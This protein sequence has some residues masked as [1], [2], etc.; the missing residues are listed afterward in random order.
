MSFWQKIPSNRILFED[1][2]KHIYNCEYKGHEA[3][4]ESLGGVLKLSIKKVVVLV[5]RLEKQ[6][7]LRISGKGLQLTP[8]GKAWALQ[9]IRAHRLWESYLSDEVGLPLE[10]LHKE[11]ERKEHEL[12]PAELNDLEARLGFPKHDPHGD[13]I[14]SSKNEIKEEKGDS[15]LDWPIGTLARI[16]HI[17]DEPVSIFTQILS[18]GLTLN[19]CLKVLE[20]GPRGLRIWTLLNEFWLAPIVAANIF[21]DTAPAWF[22]ESEVELA[23][24]L[25]PGEKGKILS[26]QTQGLNRR[27]M[28]D[29]GLVPGT[30]IKSVMISAL[31][32]PIAFEVRGSVTALRIEQANQVFIKRIKK[33]DDHHVH[34][35]EEK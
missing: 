10:K 7:S 15:I 30:I 9:V 32:D 11:A 16:T 1:A 17:E 5:E 12:S 26:I 23:S 25:K 34:V 3:S 20:S 19:S 4:L 27:R 24:S 31:R 18:Y 2:L 22:E 14:P 33:E 8:T 28:M 35:E 6:E 29:L 13:P 21:V